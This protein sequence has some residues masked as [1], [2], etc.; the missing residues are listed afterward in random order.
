MAMALSSSKNST[1]TFK[2]SAATSRA[3]RTRR[4]GLMSSSRRVSS[5]SSEI[6]RREVGA[7]ARTTRASRVSSSSRASGTARNRRKRDEDGDEDMEALAEMA[8]EFGGPLASEIYS[9]PRVAQNLLG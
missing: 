2:I 5:T 6:E 1:N 3:E 7:W 9:P 4:G 8:E